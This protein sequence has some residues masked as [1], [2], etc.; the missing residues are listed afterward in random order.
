MMRSY[1]WGPNKPQYYIV[2]T[3][4]FGFF[5]WATHDRHAHDGKFIASKPSTW[6]GEWVGE[7][8]L[9]PDPRYINLP[10]AKRAVLY[11]DLEVLNTK[12]DYGTQ[13]SG[14]GKIM[15]EGVAQPINFILDTYVGPKPT[16]EYLDRYEQTGAL[17]LRI[18]YGTRD[19]DLTPHLMSR[20]HEEVMMPGDWN[21]ARHGHKPPPRLADDEG[22]GEL[23]LLFET[24]R[25]ILKPTS[26]LDPYMTPSD[27]LHKGTL[28]E[29]EKRSQ[30]LRAAPMVFTASLD[31]PRTR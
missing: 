28:A 31:E 27:E 19:S 9:T 11:L 12:S 3:G 1:V 7:V 17:D 14:S 16:N 5:L 24:G 22:E 4:V 8:E 30:S 29:F 18:G 20:H 21:A 6:N 26:V 25:M 23:R 13:H 2:I 10:T 15:V